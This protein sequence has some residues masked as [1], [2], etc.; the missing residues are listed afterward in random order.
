MY[1]VLDVKAVD[2]CIPVEVLWTKYTIL[3]SQEKRL[4]A[5]FKS[6][7]KTFSV[8]LCMQKLRVQNISYVIESPTDNLLKLSDKWYRKCNV[9]FFT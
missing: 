6:S 1:L 2:I 5:K 7:F 4:K 8:L 3:C 9:L